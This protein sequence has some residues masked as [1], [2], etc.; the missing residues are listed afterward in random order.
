MITFVVVCASIPLYVFAGVVV[1]GFLGSPGGNFP[2]GV[3][4]DTEDAERGAFVAIWPILLLGPA[5][6][7]L[8]NFLGGLV[9]R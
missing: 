5:S 3:V 6:I 1:V 9:R 2:V 4:D 7:Y 8:L